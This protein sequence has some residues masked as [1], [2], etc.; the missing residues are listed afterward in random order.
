[1]ATFTLRPEVHGGREIAVVELTGPADRTSMLAL[2]AE[3]DL[4]AK[5]RRGA[6][7]VLLDETSLEPALITPSEIRVIVRAWEDSVA[8]RETKIAVLAPNPVLYGLNRMVQ[9]YSDRTEK[10]IGV[11]SDRANAVAWLVGE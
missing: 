4:Y 7:R 1:M 6:P 5:R 8:L 10:L 2:V 11:F 9:A 3:L